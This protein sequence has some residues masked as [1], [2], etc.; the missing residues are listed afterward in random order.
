MSSEQA[1]VVE[2][3]RRLNEKEERHE[4]VRDAQA[5]LSQNALQEKI[6]SELRKE[7]AEMEEDNA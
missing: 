2:E 5:V 3:A 6:L 7:L 1:S 4:R